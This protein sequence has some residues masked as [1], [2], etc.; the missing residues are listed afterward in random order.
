M[1]NCPQ[2]GGDLKYS[3]RLKRYYCDDC[4]Y[5][6]FSLEILAK[7]ETK[8]EE[9]IN[10]EEKLLVEEIEEIETIIRR[11]ELVD[12]KYIINCP[13]CKGELVADGGKILC[14]TCKRE[15]QRPE[16]KFSEE[17]KKMKKD[18]FNF[19]CPQCNGEYSYDEF[20]GKLSCN[21]CDY[22]P[23]IG[24][25]EKVIDTDEYS[26]IKAIECHSCGSNSGYELVQGKVLC[27]S[28]HNE[29]EAKDLKPKKI[30]EKDG[31]VAKNLEKKSI[32]CKNCGKKVEGFDFYKTELCPNCGT[33]NV[34]IEEEASL[35]VE[36]DKII[37]FS[38]KKEEIIQKINEFAKI[39]GIRIRLQGKVKKV[40]IPFWN[41]NFQGA[42]V[43]Y[44]KKYSYEDR[45]GFVK[46]MIL[47]EDKEE[48]NVPDIWIAAKENFGEEFDLSK[49]PMEK[50]EK[51]TP[52]ILDTYVE[53]YDVGT[54][55]AYTKA[56]DE[57]YEYLYNIFWTRKKS[58]N[59]ISPNFME[60]NYG[61]YKKDFLQIL[62]PF[63]EGMCTIKNKECFF[64]ISDITGEIV[65]YG[66]DE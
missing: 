44:K 47:E 30:I 16:I 32:S 61:T 53:R 19:H 51:Y 43:W 29:I 18:K 46:S 64:T 24:S 54:T 37:L 42:K 36:P 63:W 50:A 38:L 65:I 8:K 55:E 45:L 4:G 5:R 62:L 6:T 49:I 33:I 20:S 1:I 25:K 59:L 21:T 11:R 66:L 58:F 3:Q 15:Y 52:H 7:E 14:L 28:C 31:L 27:K 26:Y 35:R 57:V 13:H 22:Q 48:I 56:N 9:L 39:K 23:S 2:C 17:N 41:F 12:K 60:L 10:L 34:I 40:Y